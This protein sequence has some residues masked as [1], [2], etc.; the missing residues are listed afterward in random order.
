MRASTIYATVGT[1]FTLAAGGLAAVA[2]SA[3][4][5]APPPTKT[6]TI[7]VGE[8][9]TGPSGP[10]GERGPTGTKG[11]TGLAG[12]TGPAGGF[13]CLA[14]YSPG[15]LV[16]NSPGGKTRIYTCIEGP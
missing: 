7:N 14:G 13:V 5:E 2:L 12:P 6:V 4:G 3:T 8:G 9:T 16:I 11:D 15:I 1:A 10:S